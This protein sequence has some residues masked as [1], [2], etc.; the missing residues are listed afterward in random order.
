MGKCQQSPQELL[1]TKASVDACRYRAIWELGMELHQNESEA[2]ES[3]K[4]ARAICSQVALD[5]KAL[6]FATT[7][8]AKAVCFHVTLDAKAW[9]F[10]TVKEAKTTQACTIQEAKATCSTAIRD[11]ETQRGLSSQVSP[12]GT[13]QIHA[14]PGDA[15]HL[16]GRQKS[17]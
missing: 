11:A 14:G 8:E 2:T 15:S 5:A 4:E 1:A 17:S 10:M 3:I 9:C 7:K 13:W 6:C 16:R 12:E